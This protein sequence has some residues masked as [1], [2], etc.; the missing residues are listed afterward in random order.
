LTFMLR[1]QRRL[2]RR[3]S[4]TTGLIGEGEMVMWSARFFGLR[5]HHT[6][7]ID[8]WR[9][10]TYFRDVMVEGVFQRFEHEHFFA[11]MDDGT[12]MR[13]EVRFCVR[14]GPLGRLA[15]KLFVRRHL[16]AL[17]SKRNAMIK[18]VA[19]SG[20]WHRYLDGRPGS[21]RESTPQNGLSMDSWDGNAIL[22]R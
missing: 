4:V 6:S 1:R 2:E 14:G 8:G 19:E 10:Y 11:V 15:T 20:E 7:R 18:Q 16:I 21:L 9:P 3:L 12:R 13:D 22:R 17:L 5:F